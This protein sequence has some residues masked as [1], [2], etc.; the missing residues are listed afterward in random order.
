MQ[1]G[2]LHKN[3][4]DS[5]YGICAFCW[6]PGVFNIIF[7]EH[8]FTFNTGG[9]GPWRTRPRFTIFNFF[10]RHMRH[11]KGKSSVH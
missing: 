3:N 1:Y 8:T 4:A 10:A 11:A 5:Q 6:R 9:P 7:A 2:I